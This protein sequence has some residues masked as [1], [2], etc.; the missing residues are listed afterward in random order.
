[1]DPDS[2]LLT[3][4]VM[5]AL[6]EI[7]YFWG[8]TFLEAKYAEMLF[9]VKVGDKTL[10]YGLVQKTLNLG[11]D[12]DEAGVEAISL[13]KDETGVA[14]DGLA[15]FDPHLP[16]IEVSPTE[17]EMVVP[18]AGAAG[19]VGVS[20][21]TLK[22]SWVLNGKLLCN[23]FRFHMLMLETLTEMAE[24]TS[25]AP[26]PGDTWYIQSAD[27]TFEVRA[28]N[29]GV[30]EDGEFNQARA[31]RAV[32]VLAQVML[33]AKKERQYREFSAIISFEKRK[34]GST[35]MIKGQ[36]TE[37]VQPVG[38]EKRGLRWNG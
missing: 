15:P 35:T 34:V 10:G 25:D 16:L 36:Q 29:Q 20:G 4:H 38:T 12:R 8:K 7:L 24:L 26:Y 17:S 33:A 6:Q 3:K 21:L 13:A 30:L 32:E 27:V 5:W 22:M 2:V 11:P 14:I 28:R 9:Q 23:E 1:M 19:D 37:V 18:I 31:A